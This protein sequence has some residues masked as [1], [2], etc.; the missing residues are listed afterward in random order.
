MFAGMTAEQP[1]FGIVC[2]LFAAMTLSSHAGAAGARDLKILNADAH[3][4]EGPIWYHNRLYYV[5]YGRNTVTLWDGKTNIVFASEPGCGPSA[6]LPTVHGEFVVTCYDNG[7]IGRL[8]ADG[9]ALPA[10]TH[11]KDGRGFLGPNDFA[12]DEHGGIFFTTSGHEGPEIDGC[13]FYL[14]ADGAISRAAS[15]LHNANGLA[16]SKDGEFLYV[17]ETGDNRLLRFKIGAGASLT[18]RRVFVNLDELTKHVGH[19]WPDGVKI[20]SKGN[21]YIGQSPRDIKAPLAGMIFIV[22]AH[23]RLL[24]TLSLPSPGVPNFALSPD[25]KTL[26]VTAVDQPDKSPY[27]GKVYAISNR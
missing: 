3:F 2:V 13:V 5:E 16:V 22:D 11:D 7:S 23:A 24:R 18:D 15:D 20:D 27:R 19:I 8:S 17:V 26:Y 4:P 12:P 21:I 6:V 9:K 14:A 1:A 25:E 10:Y